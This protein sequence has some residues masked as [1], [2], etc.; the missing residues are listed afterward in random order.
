MLETNTRA[1]K[2]GTFYLSADVADAGTFTVS[3]PTGTSDGDFEQ[4]V[5][6]FIVLNSA[7]LYQPKDIGLSF[8]DTSVTVTNRT[9]GTLPGGQTGYFNFNQPGVKLPRFARG[10]SQTTAK[11]IPALKMEPVNINLA[12]P[13][14]ASSTCVAASQSVALGA[15]FVLNGANVTGGVAVF[16]YARNVVA[17][18]TTT[19]ILTITGTDII[20]RTIVETTASGTSHTGKKAFKTVTS[21]TSNASITSATIGNGVVFGLPFRIDNERQILAEIENGTAL[22][23]LPEI[24]RAT[25][26]V[27]KTLV[28]AGTSTYV[29][30]GVA[31]QVVGAGLATQTAQTTGGTITFNVAGGSAVVGLS[32][33]VANS[34]AAGTVVKNVPTS[35]TGATGAITATQSVTIV[36]DSGF[37]SESDLSVWVDVRRTSLMNGTFVAGLAVDT[38]STSTTADVFGTYSPVTTPDGSVNYDLIVMVPQPE[39]V[40]SQYAG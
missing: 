38:K 13:T 2:T 31:G 33:V 37:S 36:G 27:G 40:G 1:F 10:D 8:G 9:G 24:M 15:A 19:A 29:F 6:H 30:P 3:Y 14:T 18:W 20:G 5:G 21:V 12:A 32:L 35:L 7:K 25:T 28:D 23:R 4:G 22:A 17:A 34:A 11:R 16:D 26:L 39:Y